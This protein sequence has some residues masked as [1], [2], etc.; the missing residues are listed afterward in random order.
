MSLF[1]DN[2]Y[3]SPVR[4]FPCALSEIECNY[5]IYSRFIRFSFDKDLLGQERFSAARKY[6]NFAEVCRNPPDSYDLYTL[7]Q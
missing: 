6:W 3:Q 4:Y 5:L 7:L 2:R 1:P